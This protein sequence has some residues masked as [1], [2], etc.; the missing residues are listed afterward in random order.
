MHQIKEEQIF[1]RTRERLHR[2]VAEK[3]FERVVFWSLFAIVMLSAMG[4]GQLWYYH[5]LFGGSSVRARGV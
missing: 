4:G 3:T 1:L 2:E 5:R